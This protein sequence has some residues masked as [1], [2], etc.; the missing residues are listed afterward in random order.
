MAILASLSAHTVVLGQIIFHSDQ[1]RAL[2]TSFDQMIGYFKNRLRVPI[3]FDEFKRNYLRK[4][5]LTISLYLATIF[6]KTT[7]NFMK[8]KL[9]AIQSHTFLMLSLAL[10]M[11]S[12]KLH[13]L[14]YIDLT[15]WFYKMTIDFISE[16]IRSDEVEKCIDILRHC[17]YVHFKLWKILRLINSYFGLLFIAICIVD[18][19]EILYASVWI[20]LCTQRKADVNDNILRKWNK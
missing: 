3:G 15:N 16:D 19:I 11:P 18:F 12:I 6:V 4:L 7:L 17:K 1:I 10:F 14:F 8:S 20:F 5:F 13:A 2:L 9:E